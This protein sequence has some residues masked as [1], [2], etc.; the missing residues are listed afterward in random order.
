MSLF[1]GLWASNVLFWVQNLDK[2]VRKVYIRVQVL[3]LLRHHKA[4]PHPRGTYA[5]A[6]TYG[7]PAAV[8]LAHEVPYNSE[9]YQKPMF[10]LCRVGNG[11]FDCAW[12]PH[13][14]AKPRPDLPISMFA[15]LYG[16][17]IIFSR[18]SH[19]ESSMTS[20]RHNI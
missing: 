17:R 14:H 13:T 9:W 3:T 2:R 15:V 8:E 6:L 1:R 20:R 12:D 7:L 5:A 19:S 11:T 16:F 4:T 18:I 10:Y